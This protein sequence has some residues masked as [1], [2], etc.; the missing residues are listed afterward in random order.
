[1][2]IIYLL[3]NK[4]K[5]GLPNKYVGSKQ[6]CRLEVIDGVPT[7]IS[8]K[9]GKPYFGSA[10]SQQ[11]KD[12]LSKGDVFH[13]SVLENVPDRDGL[14]KREEEWIRKLNVVGSSEYYNMSDTLLKN[15]DQDCI[16]NKYGETYRDVTTRARGVSRRDNLAKKHGY[17]N[18]G[19]M[20]KDFLEKKSLG[21]QHKE[22]LCGAEYI[23]KRYIKGLSL[24]TFN[25]GVE[26]VNK[27]LLREMYSQ[28][29]TMIYI[30]DLLGVDHRCVRYVL[31]SYDGKRT[32]YSHLK[33]TETEF[34]KELA[35]KIINED[36]SFTDTSRELGVSKATVSRYFLSYV[37]ERLK[38]SDL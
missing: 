10:S 26:S 30:S 28:G 21:L 7:I 14:Y 4:T 20:V 6:E 1:M 9:S 2:N 25:K 38:G 22:I 3:E 23:V 11:M 37:R 27:E 18:Y 29:A 34:K 17:H 32:V 5:Q 12:E 36:K 16:L 13:T 15:R 8:N 19:E 35:N 33:M 24:E 31:G